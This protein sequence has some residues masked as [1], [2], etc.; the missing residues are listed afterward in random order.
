MPCDLWT[1]PSCGPSKVHKL[2]QLA[3]AAEPKR[4]VTL[5]KVGEDLRTSYERLKTLSKALRRAG[6]A[7]EY[8][9]VPERHRNG[10]WHFHLLQRGDYIPQRVLSERAESAGMG[11]VVH[12][13]RIEGDRQA[14]AYLVKYMSKQEPSPGLKH[15]KRYV[16]SRGFWPGGRAAVQLK[17]FGPRSGG[18]TV[19]DTPAHSCS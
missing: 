6:M 18:W 7:W 12:I 14:V 8:L 5:S 1:C 13:R 9:G 10:F 15:T 16:T 11:R 2:A 3:S 4:F 19:Q 17:A